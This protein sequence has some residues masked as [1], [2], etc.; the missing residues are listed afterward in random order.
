MMD[1]KLVIKYVKKDFKNDFALL[2]I[3][4]KTKP[5]VKSIMKQRGIEFLKITGWKAYKR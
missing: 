1:H 4:G 5:D 3:D 2:N